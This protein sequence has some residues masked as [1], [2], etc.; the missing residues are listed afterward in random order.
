MR[1]PFRVLR[2]AMM[3][4]LGSDICVQQVAGAERYSDNADTP[5]PSMWISSFRLGTT[6]RDLGEWR[7]EIRRAWRR[8]PAFCDKEPI[9]EIAGRKGGT[10]G[11]KCFEVGDECRAKFCS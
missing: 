4:V 3:S 6:Y 11:M 1:P 7:S 5:L 2:I 8:L 10:H 9:D